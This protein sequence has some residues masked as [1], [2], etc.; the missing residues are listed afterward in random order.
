MA[1]RNHP[2]A[3]AA[4]PLMARAL[5]EEIGIAFAID[6]M[7]RAQYK[8]LIY[9]ARS[10]SRDPRFQDLIIFVPAPPHD[11]ELWIAKKEVELDP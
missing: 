9:Q 5:E 8:A 10:E 4:I 11:K 1:K 7:D 2:S 6:G 3:A